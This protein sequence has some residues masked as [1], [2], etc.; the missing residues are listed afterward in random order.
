[1]KLVPGEELLC[2]L[3]LAE[4]PRTGYGA[5]NPVLQRFTGR[6]WIEKATAWLHFQKGG[7]LQQIFHGFKYRDQPD[8]AFKMGQLAAQELKASDFFKD[9]DLL[10][11]VPLHP[12]KKRL[13]GYNQAEE[14]AQ[15]MAKELGIPCA[16]KL[17]RRRRYR[18]SQTKEG[19]F[20]RWLNLKGQ[21]F[22]LGK[23]EKWEGKHVLIIDDVIT[24]G[25]TIEAC[26]SCFTSEQKVKLSVFALAQA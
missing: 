8:L 26:L 18:K 11:P 17:L 6:V 24:T 25:A 16:P 2:L 19:R 12:R 14:I 1:M 9:I 5:V 13:R 23:A 3:C 15:G 10:V 21:T 20:A 22:E 4:L 7:R